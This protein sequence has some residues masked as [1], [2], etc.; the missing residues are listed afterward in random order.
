MKQPTQYEQLVATLDASGLGENTVTVEG[1]P[2]ATLGSRLFSEVMIAGFGS[3]FLS[4]DKRITKVVTADGAVT[5]KPN[6]EQRAEIFAA[7]VKS[8]EKNR[9]DDRYDSPVDW[10]D[11]RADAMCREIE[12]SIG[13]SL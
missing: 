7:V 9:D 1:I 8:N 12:E 2:G 11:A 3:I 6:A 4:A 13:I 5:I 10:E